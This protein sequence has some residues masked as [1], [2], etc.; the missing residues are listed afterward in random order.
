MR[1]IVIY[2][3]VL[4]F[5]ATAA[6]GPTRDQNVLELPGGTVVAPDGFVWKKVHQERRGNKTM[7][8]YGASSKD[9]NAALILGIIPEKAEND[10]ARVEAVKN[11]S[12]GI[13][14]GLKKAGLKNIRLTPP[15]ARGA[16][17]DKVEFT[18]TCTNQKDE[19]V[20]INGRV[21]F[22]KKTYIIQG[23]ANT[24]QEAQALVRVTDSL[25]E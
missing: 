10:D 2:A 15:D 20:V 25:N 1:A 8:M 5:A 9:T 13:L 21:F 4:A 3:I 22:G 24:D 19:S 14:T 17:A 12:E 18:I 6:A 16:M 7:V 11:Y 23:V